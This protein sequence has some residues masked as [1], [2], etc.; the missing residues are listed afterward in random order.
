MLVLLSLGKFY[1]ALDM[2]YRYVGKK[3]LLQIC[4][5]MVVILK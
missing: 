4:Y 5:K 2:L 3:V 1:K